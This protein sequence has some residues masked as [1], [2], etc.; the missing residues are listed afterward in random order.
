MQ[1]VSSALCFFQGLPRRGRHAAVHGS[2]SL[3]CQHYRGHPAAPVKTNHPG[4]ACNLTQ[5]N[6]APAYL[7]ASSCVASAL[8]RSPLPRT[9]AAASCCSRVSSPAATC[10]AKQR[11]EQTGCAE[12]GSEAPRQLQKRTKRARAQAHKRSY[13]NITLSQAG[14]SS[15]ALASSR[16]SPLLHASSTSLASFASNSRRAG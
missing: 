4:P 13:S 12:L 16:E 5:P 2:S 7:S 14:S 8:S 3:H 1:G 9:S 10:S 15:L 6:P 11:L